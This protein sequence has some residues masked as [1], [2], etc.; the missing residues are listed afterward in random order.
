MAFRTSSKQAASA[1]PID[2][3]TGAFG[4]QQFYI[5]LVEDNPADEQL[6]REAVA[7]SGYRVRVMTAVNGAEALALM[8]RERP[9]LI[10]LDLNLPAVDGRKVLQTLKAQARQRYVPII[11]FTSS[12]AP[13]DIIAAYTAGA[14]CYMRKPTDFDGLAERIKVLLHFWMEHVLFPPADYVDRPR[15]TA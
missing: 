11:V 14:N 2:S 9:N 15:R 1:A 10:L 13:H 5:L 3:E 7:A 8:R 6:M 4:A 12:A